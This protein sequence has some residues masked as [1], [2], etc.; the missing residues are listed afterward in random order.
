M[1]IGDWGQHMNDTLTPKENLQIDLLERVIHCMEDDPVFAVTAV[2]AVQG[3]GHR[4]V[5]KA[6]KRKAAANDRNNQ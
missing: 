1:S 5:D 6:R 4:M 3:T 2:L